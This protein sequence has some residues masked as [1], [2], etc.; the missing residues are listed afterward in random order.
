MAFQV[1]GRLSSRH[2]TAVPVHPGLEFIDLLTVPQNLV[3]YA[4]ARIKVGRSCFS[5]MALAYSLRGEGWKLR[6]FYAGGGLERHLE[7]ADNVEILTL[8]NF[9]PQANQGRL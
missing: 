6:E 5:V 2:R 1:G 3:H 8:E 7:Y 4:V 9:V